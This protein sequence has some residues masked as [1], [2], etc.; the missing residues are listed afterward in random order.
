LRLAFIYIPILAQRVAAKQYNLK[1]EMKEFERRKADAERENDTWLA[2][3]VTYEQME[4]V[5]AKIPEMKRQALVMIGNGAVFMTQFF[6]WKGMFNAGYP[7][8]STG[9]ALW[10]TDLT[11]TGYVLP[12]ISAVTMF[13]VLKNGTEGFN[14]SGFSPKMQIGILCGIPIVVFCFSMFFPSGICLYWCTSNLFSLTLAHI[15]QVPIIRK[16]LN[17]P[18]KISRGETKK[19]DVVTGLKNTWNTLR[20]TQRRPPTLDD[21]KKAHDTEFRSAG[22]GKPIMKP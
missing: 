4:F 19:S 22:R 1:P 15:L 3:Q 9:G 5:N 18:G 11:A 17:I 7:G 14:A 10:F 6:A 13:F 20:E 2:A 21:L 16:Q 8:L 12:A